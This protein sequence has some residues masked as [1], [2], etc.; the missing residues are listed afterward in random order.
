VNATC[1][2]TGGA[3]F[4]GCA[5]SK[6]LAETFDQV[7]AVDNLH[8]Q[9]H[10]ERRRPLSLHPSVDLRV[11]DVTQSAAWTEILS[12]ITPDVIVHLA[13]ETGTGQS[14][15]EATRHAS[16]NVIGTTRMMDALN[17]SGKHPQ[18]IVLAS[19]RAIY[20]EGAWRKVGDEQTVYPG[21]RTSAQLERQEWDFDGMMPVPAEAATT[22][23][24]PTSVYGA[25]KLTQEQVLKSW[26]QSFGVE[27][28]ILRLQNVYGP[29][30][31]LI[32]AYTGIVSLFAR[33]AR[34][35]ESIPV[36]EDGRIVRD[37]VFI[38]DVAAAILRMV[39]GPIPSVE[40]YDIGSG[41][42]TTI[43]DLAEQIADHYRS[44]APHVNGKFRNGDV[45]FAS[46]DIGR[47][48]EQLGWQPRWSLAD[49]VRALC[50]SI[51]A[52]ENRPPVHRAKVAAA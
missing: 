45:R 41:V 11:L 37:F 13:A 15:T 34:A 7:V 6:A 33:K 46:C 30:Q 39:T 9:I 36:Y 24:Q 16:V 31:S 47:T 50:N 42:R 28:G 10:A 21:Q 3:G 43:L 22:H 2:V 18:K 12:D 49:G 26:C 25:T 38:D 1:L 51:D 35:G 23:P 48:R 27:I 52:R 44:P 32:N 14:L 19:S 5:I 8:P 40:A 29:G 17:R 20:G 4:I